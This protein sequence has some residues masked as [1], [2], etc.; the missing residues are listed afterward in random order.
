MGGISANQD[1]GVSDF[2]FE[3]LNNQKQEIKASS[4]E[5]Q[6]NEFKGIEGNF[7]KIKN[8]HMIE[9]LE[10]EDFNVEDKLFMNRLAFMGF[11]KLGYQ[12]TVQDFLKYCKKLQV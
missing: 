9:I 12:F 2:Q 4:K 1:L 11:R 6:S 5:K 8:V 3:Q 7:L 10:D